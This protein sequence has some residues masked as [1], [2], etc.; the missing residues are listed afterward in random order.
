MARPLLLCR[1]EDRRGLS[2]LLRGSISQCVDHWQIDPLADVDA[3][4]AGIFLRRF[5]ALKILVLHLYPNYS[6]MR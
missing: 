5:G 6:N 4:F 2:H 1:V 3:Q